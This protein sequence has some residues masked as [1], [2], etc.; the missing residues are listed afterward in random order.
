MNKNILL[1]LQFTA[2]L[3]LSA[4]F[5]LAQTQPNEALPFD[6]KVIRGTLSNGLTY[7]IRQNKKP[8]QKVEL[9]LVVNAG[10]LMEDD[11]QQGLAHMCEH[12]AFNG[13]KNFAKNDIINYLQTIGVGFGSD[14]NAYTGFDETVYIL[15]IPT[16]KPGNLEKGMQI[17]EDWAHQVSYTDKDINEERN[18][19]LEESRSGKGAS[20][21]M[22]RQLLPGLL[23]GSKYANRLPIGQDD[24]IKNFPLDA[25]RRFY[26]DW[27]RPN[28]MAVVAV[29]DFNP[30]EIEA[31]IKKHFSTMQNPANPRPRVNIDVPAYA[32]NKALVVTDK[33]ATSFSMAV[34]FSAI[35]ALATNTLGDY[36]RDIVKSLFGTLINQRMRELTQ[37]ENPPFLGAGVSFGGF[38]RGYD[39]FT[40]S[41]NPGQVAPKVALSAALDEIERLKKFGFI[42]AELDRIKKST[43]ASIERQYNEREKTESENY[44]EEY[45]RHFLEQE[46]VPGIENEFKYYQQ[47]LPTITLGDLNDYAKSV[48]K[49]DNFFTYLMGP[50]GEG[51]AKLPSVDD[52]IATAT[53]SKG[54]TLEPYAE[55]AIAA[56]LIAQKPTPGT[57]VK[58]S[59]DTLWGTKTWWLS[60]GVSVTLKKTSFKNDQILMGSRRAGGTSL[61]S[62]GDRFNAQYA[63]AIVDAMGIGNFRP[64]DLQKAL[65]GK[66]ANVRPVMSTYFDGFSGNSSVKDV[67]TMFQLLYLRATSPRTDT[68]L[69]KSFLQRTKSA[70]AFAMADPQTAFIDSLINTLYGQNPLAPIVVPKPSYYDQIDINKSLAIY[71]KHFGD[72]TGMNF[73]FVGAID[74]AI[75]QPLVLTYIASLPVSG[76]KFIW[77]DQG[78]R[79]VKG[80]KTLNMY[81]G[82]AD[83]SLI[84]AIHSGDV[85]YSED[86]ELK[87]SAVSEILNIRIIEELR[88]KIQGIYSGGTSVS[89]EKIPAG[90]FQF[91]FQ[92]PTGPE[93]IDT[94][95]LAINKEIAALKKNGPLAK[96]LDKVKQQWIESYK[97][98]LQEN[99]TWLNRLLRDKFPGADAKRFFNYE[100]YV[101][102]LTPAD[103]KAAANVVLSGKNVFTGILRPDPAAPAK[104]APKPAQ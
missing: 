43:L 59:T 8:E 13:T 63:T 78:V 80:N 55:K 91:L 39:Q 24:I 28:L 64:T 81:K 21:R 5:S 45:I 51:A 32:A 73:V 86:L 61:Y 89:V 69:F 103:V 104:P 35:P 50:A 23:E 26:K 3:A 97:T 29:G 76:N 68:T 18:V 57:I 16:D 87:A 41:V 79:M 71:S 60:N 54:K 92:L 90:N 66:T 6:S 70:L 12:M 20:D 65:A 17:L 82:A 44:V 93:K 62:V 96:D 38:A 56:S 22:L 95:L 14:L 15:P 94:L 85:P 49:Q 74:E 101:K 4:I 46:P 53:A 10:S 36:K 19:I 47:L 37:K 30:A 11:D 102:K 52:L 34:N 42:Q 2:L 84:F 75:L 99:G 72:L 83:K 67:E 25:I 9:R 58:T 98:S 31:M 77:K 27:Y 88:E 1:Q 40:V 7:Y 100:T 48:T 33:E